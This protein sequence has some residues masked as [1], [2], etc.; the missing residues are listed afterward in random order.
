MIIFIKKPTPIA[1]NNSVIIPIGAYQV[2]LEAPDFMPWV[3]KELGYVIIHNDKS[4]NITVNNDEFEL[5]GSFHNATLQRKMTE[6]WLNQFLEKI[7]QY[8]PT[9]GWPIPKYT[10][11]LNSTTAGIAKC[12]KNEIQLNPQLFGENF[13]KFRETVGHELAHIAAYYIFRTAG[14]D[15]NWRRVMLWI[16]LQPDRCHTMDTSNTGRFVTRHLYECSCN[17]KA[18]WYITPEAHR[19]IS[20]GH[21]HFKCTD[22]GKKTVYANKAVSVRGYKG[23]V[24]RVK[25]N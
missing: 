15:A 9:Y 16:G 17:E 22:C 5:Y 23:Q 8:H 21:A 20:I 14:H 3:T 7:K 4:V 1:D 18:K 25:D 10:L 24:R 19:K 2:H 11:D 12:G 13:M 6:I